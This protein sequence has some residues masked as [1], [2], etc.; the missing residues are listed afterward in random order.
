MQEKPQVYRVKVDSSGR[1]GL[2][3]EVRARNHIAEGDTV[4]VMEDTHGLHMK[5]R[6]QIKT[7]VQAYFATLA[8]SDVSL[9]QEIL[10]DRR[11]EHERD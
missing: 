6:E 3:A 2:P 5:T 10:N 8:P 4:T 11:A 1:I 7:A 9:S